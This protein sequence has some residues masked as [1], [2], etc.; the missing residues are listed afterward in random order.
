MQPDEKI[1]QYSKIAMG[2]LAII[3]LLQFFGD[4]L[5]K[6]DIIINLLK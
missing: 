3:I 5:D 6:L 1:V 4:I 2:I